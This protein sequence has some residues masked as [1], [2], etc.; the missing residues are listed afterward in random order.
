MTSS[1]KTLIRS[2]NPNLNLENALHI[3]R[4]SNNLF[5]GLVKAV[6]LPMLFQFKECRWRPYHIGT[7]GGGTRVPLPSRD[8]QSKSGATRGL[9][10]IKS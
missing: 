9:S 10:V 8:S 1:I 2:E 6:I 4:G 5:I 7:I 3:H